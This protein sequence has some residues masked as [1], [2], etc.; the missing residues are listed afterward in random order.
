MTDKIENKDY[1]EEYSEDSFW[2]KVKNYGLKAGED[3]IVHALQLYYVA[4]DS[5][6]AKADKLKIYAA[7][8]YFISLIDAI[9]DI[10]PLVGYADDF[11]V[12]MLVYSSIRKQIKEEHIRKAN[13]KLRSW[14]PKKIDP[15][16]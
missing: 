8:G 13:D 1:E 2:D 11:G 3:I 4:A 16:K 7:L 10:T 14:F 5:E 15:I 6:T 12:V 9:P